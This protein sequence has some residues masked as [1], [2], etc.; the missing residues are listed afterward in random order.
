M[1]RT[2]F[3][4]SLNQI[5]PPTGISDPLK[6]LWIEANGNWDAAHRLIQMNNDRDSMWVHAYLHRKEVDLGNASYWYHRA[7][8]PISSLSFDEEWD[9]IVSALLNI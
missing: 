3:K 6:A 1:N 4:R 5:N 7:N 2:E 8:I 9:E